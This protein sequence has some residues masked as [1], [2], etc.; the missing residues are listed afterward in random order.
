ME[1]QLTSPAVYPSSHQTPPLLIMLAKPLPPWQ[2]HDTPHPPRDHS[3]PLRL[4]LRCRGSSGLLFVI[5]SPISDGN[6][7]PLTPPLYIDRA[8]MFTW[9]PS[10]YLHETP[11]N[12]VG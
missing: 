10:S 6:I 12:K 7:Q 8:Q 2:P 1:K 3:L 9:L 11:F 5:Y 4:R